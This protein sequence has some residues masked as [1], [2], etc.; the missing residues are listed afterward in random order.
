MFRSSPKTKVHIAEFEQGQRRASVTLEFDGAANSKINYVH[1]MLKILF[2]PIFF[3]IK[4]I[5]L[6]LKNIVND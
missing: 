5:W 1:L 6:I 4:L 2:F 3:P